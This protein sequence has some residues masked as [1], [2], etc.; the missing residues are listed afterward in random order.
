MVGPVAVGLALVFGGVWKLVVMT[1]CRMALLE[2]VS[3]QRRYEQVP[4]MH[5]ARSSRL[6]ALLRQPSA[7]FTPCLQGS[8]AT[9]E[10]DQKPYLYRSRG[11]F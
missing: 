9:R 4:A 3:P 1:P 5:V 10:S 11:R 8:N 2:P 6:S 7:C